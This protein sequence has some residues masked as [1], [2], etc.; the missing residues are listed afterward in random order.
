MSSLLKTRLVGAAFPPCRL[1]ATEPSE[2]PAFEA[3]DELEAGAFCATDEA[4]SARKAVNAVRIVLCC[5][6]RILAQRIEGPRRCKGNRSPVT[7]KHKKPG[8][9]TIPRV[10]AEP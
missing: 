7:K 1:R 4:E 6:F 2:L 10:R 5:A 8:L 3:F 9:A